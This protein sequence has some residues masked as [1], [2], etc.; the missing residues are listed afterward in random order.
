MGLPHYDPTPVNLYPLQKIV[1]KI[2]Y[3]GSIGNEDLKL[4][5]EEAEG[6]LMEGALSIGFSDYEN[7]QCQ[8]K[9]DTLN[10]KVYPFIKVLL[11]D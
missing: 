11:L 7:C 1:L 8:T 2:F 10:A 5:K 4:T 3:R 6:K 9:E